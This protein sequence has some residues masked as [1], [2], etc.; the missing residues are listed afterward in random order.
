MSLYTFNYDLQ[1]ADYVTNN[2]LSL[3]VILCY[4][5]SQY[6]RI[7]VGIV[8][9]VYYKG[10]ETTFVTFTSFKCVTQPYRNA[11]IIG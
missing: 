5:Q 6:L 3:R 4:T 2:K 9:I 8:P 10:R 7:F 1:Y 11:S